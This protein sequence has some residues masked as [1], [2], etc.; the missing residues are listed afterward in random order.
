MDT[1]YEAFLN[2]RRNRLLSTKLY[3]VGT[4]FS[5]IDDRVGSNEV[6]EKPIDLRPHE[7]RVKRPRKARRLNH[8]FMHLYRHDSPLFDDQ[9][10]ALTSK[11]LTS[12][13]TYMKEYGGFSDEDIDEMSIS[14]P[15]LLDLSVKRHL[16]PKLRFIKYTLQSKAAIE[17][18]R[19]GPQ[20]LSD[21]AKSIP[22]QYFGSRMEKVVAPRL[23]LKISLRNILTSSLSKQNFWFIQ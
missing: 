11:S 6:K 3:D 20:P 18:D 5:S 13:R 23:V 21:I 10:I 4:T 16:R 8:S 14:F 2:P 9:K 12:A 15:P 19:Q 7:Q 22:P 1:D 17:L